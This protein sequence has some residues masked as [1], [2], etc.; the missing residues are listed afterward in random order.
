MCESLH[1]HAEGVGD[2]FG[3]KKK[4]VEYTYLHG[5]DFLRKYYRFP[6]YLRNLAVELSCPLL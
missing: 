3:K 2:W 1:L 4:W 6:G 5:T